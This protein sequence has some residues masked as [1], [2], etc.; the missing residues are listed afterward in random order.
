LLCYLISRIARFCRKSR[1]C[2]IF[3]ASN[4]TVLTAVGGTSELTELFAKNSN[5]F[6]KIKQLNL[7]AIFVRNMS[8]ALRVP[9]FSCR[10]APPLTATSRYA[11][12]VFERRGP[13]T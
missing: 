7:R 3:G 5:M 9:K 11:A 10:A 12:M 6:T 8:A 1:F 13:G 2:A 4:L